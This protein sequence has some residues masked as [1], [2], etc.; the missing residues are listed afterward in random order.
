MWLPSSPNM[1]LYSASSFSLKPSPES[2][3]LIKSSS[4]CFNLRNVVPGTIIGASC[5]SISGS[6]TGTRFPS[7]F[8][9]SFCI[10]TNIFLCG[11]TNSGCITFFRL[12]AVSNSPFIAALSLLG[13]SKLSGDLI[14]PSF[15]K[16]SNLCFASFLASASSC[17]LPPG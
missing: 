7:A 12:P 15:I 1:A 2:T 16:L 6:P 9:F 5:S 11:K 13:S 17:D 4:F 8:F 10:F 3:F 14:L